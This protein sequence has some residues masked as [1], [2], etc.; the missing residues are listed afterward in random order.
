MESDVFI[1]GDKEKIHQAVLNLLLNSLDASEPESIIDIE[2]NNK[3]DEQIVITI[4]DYGTG[5]ERDALEHVFDPF[6][7]TK[8]TGTGLGLPIVKSIIENHNGVIKI[9]SE[10]DEGT[11]VI[12]EFPSYRE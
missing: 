5:I 8:T 6:Y 9:E 10:K 12:I 1:L 7:T 11:C 2:L 3:K 4:H